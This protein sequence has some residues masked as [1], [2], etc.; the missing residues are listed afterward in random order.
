MRDDVGALS[1]MTPTLAV[2]DLGRD[3]VVMGAVARGITIARDSVF[4][5]R[6]ERA[7]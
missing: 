1:P 6:I 4:R 7:G 2:G 3:A 5:D